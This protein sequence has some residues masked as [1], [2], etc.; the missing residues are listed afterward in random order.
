MP[1]MN[2]YEV[3]VMKF[4]LCEYITTLEQGDIQKIA[5]I[6]E[7]AFDGNKGMVIENETIDYDD[8]KDP[9]KEFIYKRTLKC[10]RDKDGGKDGE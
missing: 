3:K 5:D 7:V 4:A 10:L 8:A 6:A 1:K 2:Q 9:I